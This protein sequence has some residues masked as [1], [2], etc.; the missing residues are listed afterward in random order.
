[1]PAP[2]LRMSPQVKVPPRPSVSS[3]CLA[4]RSK[5]SYVFVAQRLRSPPAALPILVP[6]LLVICHEGSS[7]PSKTAIPAPAPP[8]R[9]FEPPSR[10][11]PDPLRV[12]GLYQWPPGP[13]GPAPRHL[14]ASLRAGCP[15]LLAGDGSYMET[16]RA[17]PRSSL[18][19]GLRWHA[20]AL[21]LEE[22]NGGRGEHPE[23]RPAYPV[24]ALR[25]APRH[26]PPA[27]PYDLCAVHQGGADDGLLEVLS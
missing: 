4:V 10:H 14:A 15:L 7:L 13:S 2:V 17:W 9:S 26:T 16:I 22:G 19:S 6:A 21:G 3:R 18:P 8:D 1:M 12:L 25:E 24:Y 23:D 20:A 11:T 27:L 5:T